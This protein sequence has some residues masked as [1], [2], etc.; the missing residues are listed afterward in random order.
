MGYQG[1]RQYNENYIS[2]QQHCISCKATTGMRSKQQ[3][4]SLLSVLRR[5]A[6]T[7]TSNKSK[8]SPDTTR[9]HIKSHDHQIRNSTIVSTND[10]RQGYK[11]RKDELKLSWKRNT[12]D[13]QS[14]NNSE[15]KA[16]LSRSGI[17]FANTFHQTLATR[18][19]THIT[20]YNYG[21]NEEETQ[22]GG[23]AT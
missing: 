18:Q 6:T 2:E 12:L 20:T 15:F 11:W 7:S 23:K 4:Q 13:L 17:L 16:E 21:D 8:H 22:R 10:H 5:R 19:R 14:Q 9:C 1:L 3:S